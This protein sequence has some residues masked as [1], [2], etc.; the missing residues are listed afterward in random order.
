MTRLEI[1]LTVI[2]IVLAIVVHSLRPRVKNFPPGEQIFNKQNY[3]NGN[4]PFLYF[5]FITGI[6]ISGPWGVPIL[7]NLPGLG[8][9]P[10]KTLMTWKKTYGPIIGGKFGTFT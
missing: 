5:Y 6:G 9:S 1:I 7:G 4:I 2:F 10:L 8:V 3:K